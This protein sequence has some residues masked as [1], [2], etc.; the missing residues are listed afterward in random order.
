MMMKMVL[1]LC[2]QFSIAL[3]RSL[4]LS[5][6]SYPRWRRRRTQLASRGSYWSGNQGLIR[7]K[8]VM[9]ELVDTMNMHQPSFSSMRLLFSPLLANQPLFPSLQVSQNSLNRMCLLFLPSV[10]SMQGKHMPTPW[11][12]VPAVS[13]FLKSVAHPS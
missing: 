13:K 1:Q 12:K 2:N 9:M 8:K 3:G 4:L 11:D 7:V 5:C 10:P 6:R